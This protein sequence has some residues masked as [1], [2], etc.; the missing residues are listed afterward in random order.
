M[1]NLPKS[2]VCDENG[3]LVKEI[4]VTVNSLKYDVTSVSEME[5]WNIVFLLHLYPA[6]FEDNHK[7]YYTAS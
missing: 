1:G 2:E 3:C 4:N 5:S 7:C 6:Y